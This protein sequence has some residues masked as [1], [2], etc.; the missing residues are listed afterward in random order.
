MLQHGGQ[1]PAQGIQ[2]R[3]GGGGPRL[4][5]PVGLQDPRSR[6]RAL[7]RIK[8]LLSLRRSSVGRHLGRIHWHLSRSSL[9]NPC[10]N[11]PPP[12]VGPFTCPHL[13][14]SLCVAQVVQR[15]L[16]RTDAV[17][18]QGKPL[19]G[20]GGASHRDG[21]E[22]SETRGGMGGTMTLNSIQTIHQTYSSARGPVCQGCL[23]RE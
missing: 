22:G 12:A 23:S 11:L 7:G 16:Q 20:R 6:K 10:N 9:R 5:A 1:R 17:A 15:P 14:P 13:E 21:A 2:H 4:G 8:R 3:A 18:V 19:R